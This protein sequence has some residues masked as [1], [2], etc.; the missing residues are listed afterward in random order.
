MLKNTKIA[1]F[2]VTFALLFLDTAGCTTSSHATRPSPLGVPTTAARMEALLDTPG[3][4]AVETIDGADWAVPRSGLINLDHP[5]ARA[6]HL[7][8]GDE[9]ISVFV[10]VLHHPRRGT[11]LIDTGVTRKLPDD[12]AGAG[13]GFVV[14]SF[15]HL[16]KLHVRET[17]A[18]VVARQP[19]PL[20]GVLFTHL[21]LDH[22]MGVP[23][24]AADTP[25]YA[26]PGETGGRAF[27]NLLSR[28]SIDGLLAGH[29]AIQE[30]RY[31]RDPAGPFA[32]VLDVFGDGSLFAL[33][34]P[35]HTA[36]STAYVA[37]TPS[38]PVLFTGDACH[39]RWGWEHDVEPGTFS[40][41]RAASVP[42][43]AA[44]RALA[45]RH[46]SMTVHL[47]HQP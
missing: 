13:I 5:T 9:P 17:T 4:V 46:P 45:A 8:D 38:G 40:A 2:A 43:L 26:G 3:P 12:A 7:T 6:A 14:R 21:H 11:F 16:E 27:M 25:M 47:G 42:S 18:S 33:W 1:V 35:G 30:W 39:T 28:G 44:L 41:D 23:D 22:I 19:A 24:L 31:E 15:A 20:A 37:R 34:V 32:G 36:G 10:H 29:A